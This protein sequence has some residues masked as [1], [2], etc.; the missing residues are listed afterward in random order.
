MTLPSSADI[1]SYGGV[2]V[3]AVPLIDP[4][5][6]LSADSLNEV[7]SD[8]AA[9]TRTSPRAIFQFTGS[10]SSPTVTSSSTWNAGHDAVWGNANAVK[11]TLSRSSTGVITVTFPSS[12]TDTLGNTVPVVLRAG[13]GSIA[14]GST[15]G[16]IIVE[17]TSASTLTIRMFNSTV[18]SDLVGSLILIEVF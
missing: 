12:I 7:R 17:V 13:R 5:S 9:M 4:E 14:S 18:A 15:P 8:V 3:D 1:E 11:P 2:L 6:E 16:F 10:A